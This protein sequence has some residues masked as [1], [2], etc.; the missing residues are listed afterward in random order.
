MK[1]RVIWNFQKRPSSHRNLFA[2]IMEGWLITWLLKWCLLSDHF[3][4]WK[5]AHDVIFCGWVCL[6]TPWR[7]DVHP[8]REDEIKK[9]ELEKK[10]RG[11]SSGSDGVV[12]DVF[13]HQTRRWHRRT[14]KKETAQQKRKQHQQQRNIRMTRWSTLIISRI[15]LPLFLFSCLFSSSRVTKSKKNTRELKW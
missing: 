14:H 8:K 7:R 13:H 1:E 12:V 5:D 9:K 10:E 3:W 11:K 15:F 2:F 6:Q 4:W